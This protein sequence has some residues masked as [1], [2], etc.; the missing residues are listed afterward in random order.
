MVEVVPPT[1]NSPLEICS[2]RDVSCGEVTCRD[3]G[4]DLDLGVWGHQLVR[5]GDPF[6]DLYKK[7]KNKK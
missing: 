6:Q 4:V 1:S 5:D 2:V 3:L 7:I